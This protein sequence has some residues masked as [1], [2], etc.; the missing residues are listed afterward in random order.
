VVDV[1]FCGLTRPRDAVF[2]AELGAAFVGVIFAGGPRDRTPEEAA[3]I[4]RDVPTHVKRVGVFGADVH[5]RL[6]QVT[7]H[8]P[9]DVVQM[10]GDPG[11][12]ELLAVRALFDGEI[13]VVSRTAGAALAS[14]IDAL[15]ALADAVVLDAKVEGMLGGSGARFDWKGVAQALTEVRARTPLVVAGGL[16]VDNVAEA[17]RVLRPQI[18][19]VSSGVESAPGIKDQ[20]LMRAFMNAAREQAA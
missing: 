5:Q 9:L 17:I 13:W 3:A 12:Q 15:F 16:K 14:G 1:K 11:P 10:H 2:A 7:A 8:V 20:A 4:W 6:P 18:V 19:D